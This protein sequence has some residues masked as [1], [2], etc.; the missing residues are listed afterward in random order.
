MKS[1]IHYKACRRMSKIL[2]DKLHMK[3]PVS[4]CDYTCAE[5]MP[6][7]ELTEYVKR[8]AADQVVPGLYSALREY[9]ARI[10]DILNDT[11]LLD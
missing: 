7:T 5:F 1:C 4:C 11:A 6:V 10:G 2:A 9:R 8:T 3:R